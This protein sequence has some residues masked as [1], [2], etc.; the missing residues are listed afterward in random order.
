MGKLE[1]KINGLNL[2]I[3]KARRDK[4]E[5]AESLERRLKDE[6]QLRLQHICEIQAVGQAYNFIDENRNMFRRKVW[7]PIGKSSFL[8]C[9]LLNH[10]FKLNTK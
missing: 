6:K 5:A 4:G 3:D 7:G 2:C 9:P 8:F 1:A 10:M